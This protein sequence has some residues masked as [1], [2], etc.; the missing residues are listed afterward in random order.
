[1]E[2]GKRAD[3]AVV[4]CVGKIPVVIKTLF[5]GEEVYSYGKPYHAWVREEACAT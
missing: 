3:L 4:D 2:A 1:V 5:A